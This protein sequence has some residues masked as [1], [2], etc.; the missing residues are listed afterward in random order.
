MGC[1]SD[2]DLILLDLLFDHIVGH[3]VLDYVGYDVEHAF[4]QIIS[5]KGKRDGSEELRRLNNPNVLTLLFVQRV[6][7]ELRNKC[8]ASIDIDKGDE[9]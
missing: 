8:I 3:Y 5:A 7:I 2:S 4:A 1:S 6:G 9:R